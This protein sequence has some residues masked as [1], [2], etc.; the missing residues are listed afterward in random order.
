M[1]SP[2]KFFRKSAGQRSWRN[3]RESGR[4]AT[5]PPFSRSSQTT[6]LHGP[7]ID[8]FVLLCGKAPAEIA[9][10]GVAA[11][12]FEFLRRVVIEA[13]RLFD[14]PTNSRFVGGVED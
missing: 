9:R 8:L 5:R 13:Q 11:E 12:F 7:A 10:H 6:N 3:L 2:A 4:G 14:S 1:N